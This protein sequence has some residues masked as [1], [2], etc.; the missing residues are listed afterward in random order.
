MKKVLT[1]VLA[2]TALVAASIIPAVAAAP[3][4]GA[5]APHTVIGVGGAWDGQAGVYGNKVDVRVNYSGNLGDAEGGIGALAA[6]VN[7]VRKDCPATKLTLT[8]YSQGAAIVHVYLS[9]HGLTNGNAVLFADPK[10]AGTGQADGLFR[11]GGPP[12]AGTD[13]NFRGVPVASVCYHND[14]ICSMGAPSGWWGYFR[15]DHG[16]YSFDARAYAGQN[17]I[18]WT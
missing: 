10:Q 3:S 16:R 11:W 8:G 7:Q 2:A 1:R 14:V 4:A 6:T 13:A 15:G 17:G 18:I 5:C 9:R 12:I